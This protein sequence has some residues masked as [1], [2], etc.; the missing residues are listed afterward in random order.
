MRRALIIIALGLAAPVSAQR[1][2]VGDIDG[3][4]Q[5]GAYTPCTSG[6]LLKQGAS[7]FV[8]CI[9]PASVTGVGTCLALAANGAN[10]AAGS[11]PL[12]VDAAGAAE[13]C[14]VAQYQTVQ[15][16]GS[17]VTQRTILNFAGAGVSCADDGGTRT[18]CTIPAGPTGA[19]GAEGA[20]GLTGPE[21]ATGATGAG[22][23]GATGATGPENTDPSPMGEISYSSNSS[24]TVITTTDTW[25][26]LRI[27]SSLT[28]GMEFD[29]PANSQL[30]Y[31][32]STTEDAH[33]G[34]TLSV[35]SA[36]ANDTVKAMLC[37]DCT[38]N[39]DSEYLTGTQLTAGVIQTKLSGAGD[40]GSTAIH[41]MPTLAANSTV[42]IIIKNTSDADD[43]TVTDA[44]VFCVILRGLR[45][46]TG[47][48]GV[49]ATGPTGPTGVGATG[50]TGV[51]GDTGAVG[52][53]GATGTAGAVGATGVTGVSGPSGPTGPSKVIMGLPIVGLSAVVAPSTTHTVVTQPIYIT[54]APA[55]NSHLMFLWGCAPSGGAGTANWELYNVTESEQ[56]LTGS[57]VCPFATTT[58]VDATGA[59]SNL[60]PAATAQLVIRVWFSAANTGTIGILNPTWEYGQ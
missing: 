17:G 22:A 54:T 59:A 10:C 1:I 45:G 48:T 20:T 7:A 55:T 2:W 35:K 27:A 23:T 21:G 39:G 50:A 58:L 29:S 8:D 33:C 43:I 9:S 32:G 5:S 51:V 3:S 41:V 57:G 28:M 60:P 11:Y 24:P 56:I 14:T 44:N 34:C 47:A 52:A 25:T 16:E 31:T 4:T 53:T 38:Y 13:T 26:V 49:G 6:Q 37:Q 36:G 46:P 42:D 30:R 12:G 19:T 40:V 18:T 15:D